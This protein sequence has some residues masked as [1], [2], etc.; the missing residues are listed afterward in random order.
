MTRLANEFID[1]KTA[2]KYVWP[3]NHTEEAEAGVQRTVTRGAN[4]A[5]TGLVRQQAD[6]QP[7]V[8]QFSGTIFSQDQLEEMI[9]WYILCKSQTIQFNKYSGDE[10]E[11]IITEFKPTEKKTVHNPK[12]FA[13]APLWY[14]GY[15]IT[16]E[17]VRV[18]SGVWEGIVT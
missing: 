3:V 15:T 18:V 7:L 11:V 9:A 1:P 5:D 2:K 17:V 8:F 14:W 12:D 16:M 4:T 13:N 10:Y 6:D